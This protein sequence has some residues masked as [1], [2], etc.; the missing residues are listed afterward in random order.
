M[1]RLTK[2]VSCSFY[3]EKLKFIFRGESGAGKTETTKRVLQYFTY[4]AIKKDS[5]NSNNNKP[6]LEDHIEAANTVL[7]AFGNAKTIRNNNS[8]RFVS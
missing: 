4:V 1:N 5:S 3:F 2:E 8:S 6:I 7:E